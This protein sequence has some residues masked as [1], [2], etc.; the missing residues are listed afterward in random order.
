MTVAGCAPVSGTVRLMA[1][2]ARNN[3]W[4]N[5]RLL[6]AC[7]RLPDAGWRAPRSGFFPSI[8]ATLTHLHWVDR[9]YVDA[10]TGGG[11]GREVYRDE[12]E[13]GAEPAAA[14]LRE[15]Q[16]GLDATLC[17]FCDGLPSAGLALRV[18]TDRGG[19]GAVPER[20]DALLLHLFQHQIHHRGQA[21]AMLAGTL[22]APPQ[23]DDFHLRF[24]RDA[25]AARMQGE[26]R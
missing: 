7:E 23:L 26:A 9:Y 2:M 4:A 6:R 11:R 25:E 19:A 17:H 10:L 14:E 21:H 18:S 1:L 8:A 5:A 20:V 22:V 3:A 15:L 12:P 16:A 13:P 24:E